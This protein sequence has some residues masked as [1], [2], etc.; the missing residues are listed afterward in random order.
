[1][2]LC[3]DQTVSPITIEE[4]QWAVRKLP[5][6]KAL[7]SDFIPNEVIKL[8]VNSIFPN[9]FLLAFNTCITEGL[10]PGK[11]NRTRLFLL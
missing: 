4:L 7:D 8:T 3:A 9:T 5:S 1:M 10:F 6:N 11:W 2:V